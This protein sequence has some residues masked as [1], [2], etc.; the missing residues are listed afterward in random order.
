MFICVYV[1]KVH[2]NGDIEN[3]FRFANSVKT[4]DNLPSFSH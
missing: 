1:Y 2:V 4:F 3:G